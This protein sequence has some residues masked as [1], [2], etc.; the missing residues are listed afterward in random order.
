MPKRKHQ[1]F[2]K[3]PDKK[4][5]KIIIDIYNIKKINQ[6]VFCRDSLSNLNIVEK[7]NGIKDILKEYYIPSKSK[8]YLEDITVKRAVV[9]LRQ[10]LKKFDYKI[11]SREKY[12]NRKKY[13]SYII[14][15]KGPLSEEDLV[16]FFE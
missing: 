16:V 10:I 1:L 15:Y 8:V 3:F 11:V 6:H 14:E 2:S 12:R 7:L 13:I 4:L 9:I 5:L